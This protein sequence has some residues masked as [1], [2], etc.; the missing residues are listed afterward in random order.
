MCIFAPVSCQD[1]CVTSAK[2]TYLFGTGWQHITTW[3]FQRLTA[4]IPSPNMKHL[5][6]GLKY[7][8]SFPTKP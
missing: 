6:Y 8:V 2:K 4:P 5:L 7:V 1:K 3:C